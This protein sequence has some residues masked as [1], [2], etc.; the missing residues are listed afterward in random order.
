SA[1][2]LRA[3]VSVNV[4]GFELRD[5][6]FAGRVRKARDRHPGSPPSRLRLEVLESA[7]LTDMALVTRT[8]EEC[9]A[10]GVQFS[11]DD[12]GTGYSSLAYMKR[13]PVTTIKIDRSF[14]ADMLTDAGDRAIVTGV[15]ELAR[16]FGRQSVAE[17]VET[18]E[19][20]DA[21][22]ELRCDMGQG[23]GIAPPMPADEFE[24]WAKARSPGMPARA[25]G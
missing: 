18:Q 6:A 3:G 10:I 16:V 17:G 14:V 24:A 1:H 23:Y 8:I 9:A 7:A 25:R 20:V 12:F 19:H 13:L 2:G 21:L 22:R 4:S 15:V 11:L 5:P